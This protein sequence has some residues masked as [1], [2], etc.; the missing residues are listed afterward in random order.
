MVS[1]VVSAI[2]PD[3]HEMQDIPGS[4]S[5]TSELT[6]KYS[7]DDDKMSDSMEKIALGDPGHPSDCNR[8]SPTMAPYSSEEEQRII[9]KFDCHLVLFIALLYMLG[10]LDRSNIGN[11]KIAG[12][13]EDLHLNSSQYEWTLRSFYITYVLFEWMPILYTV[14]PP[15]TYIALCV[16]AWG[17]IASLQALAISYPSLCIL[18]A[19]LGISE[20]AF[21]PGVPVFLAFFYKR[22]ELAFRIG[23]FIS[24]APLATSFASSLAWLITKLGENSPIAPWRLL[25]LAEG[26]PSVLISIFAFY[27][28]P[29]RPGEAKYLNK[30]ERRIAQLRLQESKYEKQHVTGRKNV[31]W[32][33]IWEAL[34]DPKCYL[35]AVSTLSF[36][37]DII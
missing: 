25:F 34:R 15:S 22:D 35:T 2:V 30:R 19:L 36:S 27:R 33:E 29:N 28:I 14:M 21:G 11:A 18:R 32:K 16:L 5:E 20:A 12:M 8:D 4:P 37:A 6:G 31:K 10:F 26:F 17:T 7:F 24:A 1:S 23:L 9:K 3:E 13:S